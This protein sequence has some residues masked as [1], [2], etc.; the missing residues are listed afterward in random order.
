MSSGMQTNSIAR[1]QVFFKL[2]SRLMNN[3]V[4]DRKI[5]GLLNLKIIRRKTRKPIKK[6]V[7]KAR[8]M[9]L[10]PDRY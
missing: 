10:T 9:G 5:T 2:L 1:L 8:S 4:T 6:Y 3:Q 7:K